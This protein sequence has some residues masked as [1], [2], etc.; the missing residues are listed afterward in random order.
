MNE[1]LKPYSKYVQKY[2]LVLDKP[3]VKLDRITINTSTDLSTFFVKLNA[4]EGDDIVEHFYVAF[5]N[6]SKC[7][8]GYTYLARGG[9]TGVMADIRVILA[10]AIQSGAVYIAICHNHPSGSTKPSNA[11]EAL[12]MKLKES[13]ATHDIQ[14]MDHIIITSDESYFSFADEGLL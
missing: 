13:A 3:L 4:V 9:I 1:N 2:R 5:F 7:L 8:T 14:L 11:D 6:R 12:T 10:M